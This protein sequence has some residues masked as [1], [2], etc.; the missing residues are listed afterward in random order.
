MR[1]I[2]DEEG[3]ILTALTHVEGTEVQGTLLAATFFEDDGEVLL[4]AGSG[5]LDLARVLS[6][7]LDLDGLRNE[8]SFISSQT[9]S[10]SND[11]F[12][13]DREALW[14]NCQSALTLGVSGKVHIAGH[15]AL[16][17]KLNLFMLG[18]L[19]RDEFEIN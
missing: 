3:G 4:N 6:V 13:V 18:L 9:D 19:D 7:N 10:N 8:I 2:V 11:L 1:A 12:R 5:D 14:L 16:V 15:S 17:L